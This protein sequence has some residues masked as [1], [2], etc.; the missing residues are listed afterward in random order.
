MSERASGIFLLNPT[1]SIPN[2]QH[3][4]SE[5][6]T[7]PRVRGRMPGFYSSAGCLVCTSGVGA[8]GSKDPP[9]LQR[10][11]RAAQTQSGPRPGLHSGWV[12][13]PG[14][15]CSLLTSC[16]KEG[17]W[18]ATESRHT[19]LFLELPPVCK[20]P[21]P[22]ARETQKQGTGGFTMAKWRSPAGLRKC[23]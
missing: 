4:K 20:M 13:P 7:S 3:I 10:N 5:G 6:P 1:V 17:V 15:P 19:V 14:T 21:R 16:P 23:Q 11:T 18:H 2:N 9:G 8:T 12:T 22:D